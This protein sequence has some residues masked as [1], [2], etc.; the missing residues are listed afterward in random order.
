MP[1][2][3]GGPT[4]GAP[5]Q[6]YG[7]RT[8]L[9]S[10]RSLPV[11]AAPGQ[12]YGQ[13]QAQ[14]EAQ[15]AVPMA[16]PTAPVAPTAPT[17]GGGPAPGMPPIMP[18]QFGGLTRPTERPLEP[19]TAGIKSGPGPGPEVLPTT[20]QMTGNPNT[21]SAL[22]QKAAQVTNSPVLSQM[23]STAAAAGQ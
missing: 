4:V 6:A 19:V 15:R 13:R 11:R 3:R 21:V 10:E 12:T 23:A 22:L 18:G 16:A 5:G 17:G 7:N 14:V 9:N 1:R 20:A 2:T 8:D